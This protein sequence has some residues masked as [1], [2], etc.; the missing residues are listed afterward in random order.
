[1][2]FVVPLITTALSALG[3]AAANKGT[4][5]TQTSSPNLSPE[6]QALYNRLITQ[7]SSMMG[8]PDLGGYEASQTSDINHLAE[9]HKKN[10]MET[11]AAR[12][13]SGPATNY[14]KAGVDTQRFADISRLHQSLPL[15]MQ[16][17]GTENINTGAN[18]L[19][20]VQPGQTNTQSTPG[21]SLSGA[22]AGGASTLAYLLGQ[23][24][25]K[26]KGGGGGG[27]TM[28]PNGGGDSLGA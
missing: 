23:G 9:L 24:A 6:Q 10:L 15:L 1:M 19:R 11:L 3:S 2:S 5:N 18:L 13:I 26:S 21:N 22:L 7:Q 27:V 8:G 28:L 12:G 14:A 20:S 17:F 25:F 16:Q 4:K